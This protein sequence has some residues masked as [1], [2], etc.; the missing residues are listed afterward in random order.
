MLVPTDQEYKIIIAMAEY[1]VPDICSI[2]MEM[3]EQYH[4]KKA[5][6]YWKSSVIKINKEYTKLYMPQYD[7]AGQIMCLF[8]RGF[9][10]Y[11][12]RILH[13]A[14]PNT[15]CT[16]YSNS[17]GRREVGVLPPNYFFSATR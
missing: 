2:I 8:R 11:N 16:L 6:S 15:I 13:Q 17:Y 10:I 12:Y 3:V 7:S 5:I 4:A 1:L 14:A 9:M